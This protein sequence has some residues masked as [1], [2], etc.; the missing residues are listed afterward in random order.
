MNIISNF[1]FER[2]HF[3]SNKESAHS[4]YMLPSQPAVVKRTLIILTRSQATKANEGSKFT[5]PGIYQ[6]EISYVSIFCKIPFYE[7][8]ISHCI[9]WQ[10]SGYS[11]EQNE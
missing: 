3:A 6:V 2:P 10:N 5:G 1:I 9:T 4:K 8:A 7:K 11:S